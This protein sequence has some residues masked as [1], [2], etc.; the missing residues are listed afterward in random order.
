MPLCACI[1]PSLLPT[2][3][4]KL[5]VLPVGR[6]KLTSPNEPDALFMIRPPD[7]MTD[8]PYLPYLPVMTPLP[9]QLSVTKPG[10]VMYNSSL[11]NTAAGFVFS[12]VTFS[13]QV[14]FAL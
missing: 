11:D 9:L 12:I 10:V 7:V 2:L 4:I 6:V 3:T 8:I 13:L 14:M 1:V 5:F